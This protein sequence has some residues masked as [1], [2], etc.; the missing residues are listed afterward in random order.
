MS[1]RWLRITSAERLN[2]RSRPRWNLPT[3]E[4]WSTHINAPLWEQ[5]P[6][7]PPVRDQL[8]AWEWDLHQ[9]LD[10]TSS[11]TELRVAVLGAG[12]PPGDIVDDVEGLLLA[13]EELASNGFRH[14]QAPV[15]ATVTA[16]GDGWLVDVTDAAVDRAPIPAADR[17]PAFGGMGLYLVSQL[18]SAY[19][20]SVTAGRKHVWGYVRLPSAS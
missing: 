3:S 16:G 13:Y 1:N 8:P 9:A 17:D 18:C 5:R 11:R 19:G 20:W 14:G 6:L 4:I 10:L 7:P 2:L 15:Q 12:V